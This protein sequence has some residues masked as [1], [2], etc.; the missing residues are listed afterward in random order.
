MGDRDH[1]SW[2]MDVQPCI[3]GF[4][5]VSSECPLCYVVSLTP[6]APSTPGA[7]TGAVQGA[8]A[9]EPRGPGQP[10]DAYYHPLVYVYDCAAHAAKECLRRGR[11]YLR[12]SWK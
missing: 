4:L 3:D 7:A 8:G 11:L 12:G 6:G 5:T 10:D 1:W 9:Q 2:K